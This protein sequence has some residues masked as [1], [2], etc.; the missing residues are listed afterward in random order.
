MTKPDKNYDTGLRILEV[1]KILL[2][3]D[4]S[5]NDLIAKMNKNPDFEN[6]YTF[7]A[8]IK[9]FNTLSLLGFD[10]EKYKNKYRLKN[11]FDKIEL[12]EQEIN[13][14]I[15]LISYIK[16]LH[17]KNLEQTIQNIIQKSLK[18]LDKNSQNIIE[19]ALLEQNQKINNNNS[20]IN[21]FERLMY[22]GQLVNIT[23]LKRNNIQDT[24]TVQ[25]KEIIERNG[26]VILLC[27]EKSKTRNKKINISSIT[28]VFQTPEMADNSAYTNDSVV[29]RVYGRLAKL[30]KLKQ[31]EKTTD[32]SAGYITIHNTG[33][34]RDILLKRLLKY[35]ENCKIIQ[36]Q[37][38]K[39]EF[40]AMT[41]D[42]LKNLE[43]EKVK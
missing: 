22:D 4:V 36:P 34:D 24:I 12:S 7:E 14:A 23:Y 5:K 39:D 41:D 30:Y 43:Q 10:I 3:T 32:F 26:E 2:N 37:S 15:D 25:I 1:L 29:F 8:F 28:S 38:L 13:S 40:L 21:Y 17:N 6:V 31:G 11:A 20:T 27:Y 42:I 33:E 16:K 9:Y 19:K 18:F 35:G